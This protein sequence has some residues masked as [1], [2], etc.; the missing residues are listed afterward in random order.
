MNDADARERIIGLCSQALASN[1]TD[2]LAV[3]VLECLMEE[4]VG[5]T[6]AAELLER[7]Y[8]AGG[9]WRKLSTVLEGKLAGNPVPERRRQLLDEL[10]NIYHNQLDEPALAFGVMVRAFNDSPDDQGVRATLANL[11]RE[12]GRFEELAGIFLD[13]AD[14]IEGTALSKDLREQA[15]QILEKELAGQTLPGGR[16]DLSRELIRVYSDH[17]DQHDLAF[18]LAC[19]VI[20]EDAS[21]PL[22]IR[23][24]EKLGREVDALEEVAQVYDDILPDLDQ[25]SAAAKG[26]AT[27]KA[28]IQASLTEQPGQAV[29]RW[30]AVLTENPEDAE[31]LNAL[32]GLLRDS[33]N[34]LELVDVLKR[35]ARLETRSDQKI[36]LLYEI[37]Q[38]TEDRPESR[39]QAVDAYLDILFEDV[40]ETAAAMML[41]RLYLSM[42][43][44]SHKAA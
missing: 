21:D 18:L 20:R 16:R 36:E 38:L 4:G 2:T 33:G 5:S 22:L 24:L 35:L 10:F 32:A 30:K 25:E 12:Q 37:A 40:N 14:G 41:N 44:K 11:A 29:A 39:Q 27:A 8:L 15:A 13:V 43:T 28:R 3:G 6:R 17:L 42:A 23:Q 7:A 9:L 19:R 26:I 34:R 31:A 1:P